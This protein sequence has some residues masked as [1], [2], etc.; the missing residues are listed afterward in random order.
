MKTFNSILEGFGT[1]INSPDETPVL[2][3][4]KTGDESDGGGITWDPDTNG[5]NDPFGLSYPNLYNGT[6]GM[7]YLSW[8]VRNGTT[9]LIEAS[10]TPP[11]NSFGVTAREVFGFLAQSVPLPI[12]WEIT[13]TVPTGMSFS[14]LGDGGLSVDYSGTPSSDGDFTFTI[15]ATHTYTSGRKIKAS[16]TVTHRIVK[17][18]GIVD[19]EP[20]IALA[21]A[22]NGGSATVSNN[23]LSV[24]PISGDS[25]SLGVFGLDYSGLL[26]L[27]IE[28]PGS[29][30][31]IGLPL[32]L[33]SPGGRCLFGFGMEFASESPNHF[34]WLKTDTD[35]SPIGT[36][37]W[38]GIHANP[39]FDIEIGYA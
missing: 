6:V 30:K 17:P 24:A 36:Y 27:G 25:S 15:H 2:N 37:A 11:V 13:G 23:L 7:A 1:P 19:T 9:G 4:V 33:P 38:D 12:E 28:L 16:Q 22:L 20:L 39:G 26:S 8:W 10:T 32:Y 3:A 29:P 35:P 18:L 5:W 31:A 14:G 34:E 21:V